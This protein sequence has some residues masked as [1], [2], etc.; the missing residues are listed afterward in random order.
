MLNFVDDITTNVQK[1]NVDNSEFVIQDGYELLNDISTVEH[2]NNINM[3]ASEINGTVCK[4]SVTV[5]AG[6][7]NTNIIYDMYGANSAPLIQS[8]NESFID[9]A[10]STIKDVFD[11]IVK[12][13]KKVFSFIGNIIN[14]LIKFI[15]NI[16]KK[17]SKE[18]KKKEKALKNKIDKIDKLAKEKKINI[19]DKADVI[20]KK[21][22]DS[23]DNP[24]GN[25]G[26]SNPALLSAFKTLTLF[27]PYYSKKSAEAFLE[28]VSETLSDSFYDVTTLAEY[29]DVL[30]D[31]FA[32][33]NVMLKNIIEVSNN[34]A[35]L[36]S[37][38]AKVITD[39]ALRT[40]KEIPYLISEIREGKRYSAKMKS[41]VKLII[42][43]T[44]SLVETDLVLI[45]KVTKS[46]IT[47][48]CYKDL[49]T[50][51]NKLK[52][53]TNELELIYNNTNYEDFDSVLESF[54]SI[55]FYYKKM[56]SCFKLEKNIFS[57]NVSDDRIV[58]FY[59]D[60]SLISVEELREIMY[61]GILN[62][63]S[64]ADYV[65]KIKEKIKDDTYVYGI[66]QSLDNLT[67]YIK[68]TNYTND[69]V[70][71]KITIILNNFNSTVSM[72]VKIKT[73]FYNIVYDTFRT[74]LSSFSDIYATENKILDIIID[75]IKLS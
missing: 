5:N 10:K 25:K 64:S 46:D 22:E 56:F 73:S 16:F 37:K 59:S 30:S 69:E 39:R 9:N 24:E 40:S 51:L 49:E 17:D 74:M 57:P 75:T 26:Y 55:S 42:N 12:N 8:G 71:K 19:S 47:Y 65:E 53:M 72:S 48:V 18:I 2:L 66:E 29:S 68:N 21:I 33:W 11:Y 50:S 7:L 61:T 41:L 15:V 67:K 31:V 3:I 27:G 36:N 63:H 34:A 23:V 35:T 1:V 20:V 14:K 58:Q 60:R 6:I 45:L 44:D 62:S 32:E 13:I 52:A 38:Q 54:T 70:E 4:E 43:E 28:I